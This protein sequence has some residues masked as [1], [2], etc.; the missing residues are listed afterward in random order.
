MKS[1]KQSSLPEARKKTYA[2]PGLQTYGNLAQI[3]LKA[4]SKGQ[5]D[6]GKGSKTRTR[7]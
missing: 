4:G 3:T 5:P 2:K 6:G 1:Q 7:S